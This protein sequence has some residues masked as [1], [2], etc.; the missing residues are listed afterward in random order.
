M[1]GLCNYDVE[2]AIALSDG[3]KHRFDAGETMII[4]SGKFLEEKIGL[5]FTGLMFEGKFCRHFEKGKKEFER[6]FEEK[7]AE[8]SEAKLQNYCRVS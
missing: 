1:R 5:N 7:F 4:E 3:L 2:E 8:N 6:E